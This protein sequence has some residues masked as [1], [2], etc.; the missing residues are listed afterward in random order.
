MNHE[1]ISL[2]DALFPK[3]RQLVLGL[4]YGQPDRSF[5]TNEIIRLT[6]SGSGAVQRELEKLTLAGLITLQAVGKQKRYQVNK[7]SPLFS[8]LRGIVLKTFGL[9]DVLKQALVPIVEEIKI[10]FIYGSVAKQED[11]ANSDIDLMLISDNLSYAEL[12]PLL[13]PV[14]TKLGRDINP[15]FYSEKEWERKRKNQNHFILQII[16][17]PKIFLVGT[18]DAL[19]KLR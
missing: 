14:Q 17:Q 5:N 11:T 8:E 19:N 12:F 15:S 1:K 3:V 10:A 13:E 9:A 18:E 16:K 7:A 4:F 6:A 2:A